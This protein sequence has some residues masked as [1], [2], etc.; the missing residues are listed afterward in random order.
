MNLLFTM[1]YEFSE[2]EDMFSRLTEKK[3][4]RIP[5]E[6]IEKLGLKIGNLLIFIEDGEDII[7]KKVP[8]EKIAQLMMKK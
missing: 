7:L 6:I 8:G 1:V 2:Q 5:D 4:V 3:Q